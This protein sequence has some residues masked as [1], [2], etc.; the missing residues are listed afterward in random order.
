MISN[1]AYKNKKLSNKATL[2][3]FVVIMDIY[4]R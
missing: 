4:F 1:R 3:F 2:S